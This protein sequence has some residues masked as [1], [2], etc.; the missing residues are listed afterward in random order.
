MKQGK[1]LGFGAD[2]CQAWGCSFVFD[3]SRWRSPTRSDLIGLSQVVI[4]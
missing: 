2:S 4:G 3:E 1:T